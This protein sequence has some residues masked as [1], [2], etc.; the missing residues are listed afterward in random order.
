MLSRSLLALVV[1][2]G[3][4]SVGCKGI[5]IPLRILDASVRVAAATAPL[6]TSSG[7]SRSDAGA[8]CDTEEAFTPAQVTVD[9]PISE[10]EIE[11]GRWREAHQD[12]DV[13]PPSLRCLADGTYPQVP[14]PVAP[15]TPAQPLESSPEEAPEPPPPA[16]SSDMI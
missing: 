16:T 5:E 12:E 4:A 6:W 13:P 1:V 8:C 2:S 14:A 15:V 3:I 11:R 7:P 9:R 10:C